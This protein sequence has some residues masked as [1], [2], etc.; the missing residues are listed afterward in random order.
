[1][2]FLICHRSLGIE[3]ESEVE[4]WLDEL[5]PKQFG[6]VA[7]HLDRLATQGSSLR[8]PISRSLDEVHSSFASIATGERS[9]S[10]PTSRPGGAACC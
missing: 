6:T 2:S 10:P 8:M 5:P 4:R 9:E 1:M 3:L 7:F